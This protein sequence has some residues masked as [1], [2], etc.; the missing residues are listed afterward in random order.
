LLRRFRPAGTTQ[1][2]KYFDSRAPRGHL[3]YGTT[4][5]CEYPLERQRRSLPLNVDASD[6]S[7]DAGCR[8]T[9]CFV[10]CRLG[11]EARSLFALGCGDHQDAAN[12]TLAQSRSGR[13]YCI[14]PAIVPA[15]LLASSHRGPDSLP[16]FEQYRA[17]KFRQ[18]RYADQGGICWLSRSGSRYR[19]DHYQHRSGANTFDEKYMLTLQHGKLPQY[20]RRHGK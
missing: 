4:A 12:G 18:C 10:G 14:G 15:S 13:T 9:R 17:T 5:S 8:H 7:S 2:P 6:N 16:A 3:R 19:T 1:V 11:T 20:A